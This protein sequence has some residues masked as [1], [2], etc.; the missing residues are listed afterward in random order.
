MLSQP[1][2]WFILVAFLAAL[3][4]LVFFH[5]LGHYL[6]ARIFGVY[7]DHIA[8]GAWTDKVDGASSGSVFMFTNAVP[9]RKIDQVTM[10]H[11]FAR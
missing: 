2:L 5:E 4:P 9:D 10:S 6:V 8:V 11:Q 7:T 3:G 1:P